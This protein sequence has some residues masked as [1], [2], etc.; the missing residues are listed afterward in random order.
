VHGKHHLPALL[1]TLEP[2]R[3]VLL[4]S[5]AVVAA[6]AFAVGTPG[7]G[8]AHAVG[9]QHVTLI[10]D[11]VADAIPV[12]PQAVATLKQGID[13]DLE[14]EACRRVD[15]ESCPGPSGVRPPNV[16][17]LVK[18]MGSKLGANV[19]ISVGYNDFEDQYAQNIETALTALKAAG[20]KHVW[21]LTLRAA[22]HPYITMN[23]D[24]VAA[25]QNHPEM[26][27][28][29][30]NVY[31][32]SHL[33]WFQADGLHLLG[34]GSEAMAGLIHTTLLNDGVALKP[35]H[36]V[37]TALPVA[38]RGKPYS[39]KLSAAAGLAPYAWS[40]LER[41][42]K[43][44]HLE[45]SGAIIGKPLVKLGVYVLNAKVKDAA[46]SFDTHRLVLRV[47]R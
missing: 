35:V 29:D 43:G 7:A 3:G 34:P 39:A 17:Q 47:R 32:R 2:M 12:D 44:L 4:F 26:S 8:S 10:G 24:I 23:D 30:W 36:V 6:F 27:V 18:S 9:L 21:W 25:A 31:S 5:A 41:A 33:D 15:Q 1:A 37:T 38:H 42:P 13:L 11:S 20:V 28:I 16:V 22:H 14:V 40:L 45:S 46:G 19:V